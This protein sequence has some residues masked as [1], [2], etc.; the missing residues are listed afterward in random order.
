[1]ESSADPI[2]EPVA[3]APDRLRGLRR[4]ASAAW[5]FGSL[6]A[7]L[8]WAEFLASVL[9]PWS[10]TFVALSVAT[11]LATLACVGLGL[12]RIVAGPS[13][14]RALGLAAIGLMP[15]VLVVGVIVAGALQ[16]RRSQIAPTLPFIAFAMAGSSIGEIEAAWRYPNRIESDR[17]IMFYDRK[18]TDPRGDLVA[19]ERHVA[20]LERMT[21]RPLR[22]KIAWVRGSLLG[23]RSLSVG[24]LALASDASPALALDRHEL[25]H[26]VMY[27]LM[28][29]ASAPPMLLTEGWA[30]SQS[31]D[32]VTLAG[33][34]L[35][36][37]DKIEHMAT[38]PEADFR[39]L[40]NGW[41]DEEGYRVLVASVKEVG[42]RR[43]RLLRELTGPTW[44]HR[45][46]GSVYNIGGAFVDYLVRDHGAERFVDLY[47][48]AR[49]G[50]FDET[51]RDI[52][53][54][55][56]DEAEAEFWRECERLTRRAGEAR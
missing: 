38:I 26:A 43:L 1:M 53:G 2:A 6:A 30:E 15:V 9:R 7:S 37:R 39:A 13:R 44:Y 24:R 41:Q 35:S 4:S 14:L 20:N 50:S 17:L 8:L 46:K 3:P 10:W 47:L 29:P 11:L 40:L 21:R 19:M 42:P 23:Q 36:E 52:Y 55:P 18:I 25:A 5:L 33:R 56:L 31:Q 28:T 45:D 49:P 48:A 16:Y 22:A 32:A 27:Q 12:W 51:F 54:R 34:A